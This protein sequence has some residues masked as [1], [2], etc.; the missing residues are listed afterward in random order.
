M[1]WT[2]FDRGEK[3]GTTM[4]AVGTE[5]R[6]TAGAWLGGGSRATTVEA[7]TKILAKPGTGLGSGVL[8]EIDGVSKAAARMEIWAK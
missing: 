4:V 5:V 2:G 7:G 3:C 8:G 1:A 6:V